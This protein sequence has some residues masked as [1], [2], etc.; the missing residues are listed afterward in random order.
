MNNIQEGS[1]YDCDQKFYIINED[2]WNELL[3]AKQLD[4]IG[5][6]NKTFVTYMDKLMKFC[7]KHKEFCCAI[8]KVYFDKK[9]GIWHPFLFYHIGSKRIRVR[10]ENAK[11]IKC[12]WE[13][14]IA[15]PTLPDLY[16]TVSDR[17]SKMK[18]SYGNPSVGCP[19]CGE[20]LPRFA[21]WAG[22]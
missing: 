22:Q 12:N 8:T 10:I 19:C 1:F 13:G 15:N 9:K 16:E 17:F 3:K 2:K 18:A 20:K 11:C 21:V 6:D 7:G 14:I 5:I 4:G